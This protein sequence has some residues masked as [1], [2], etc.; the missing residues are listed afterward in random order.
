MPRVVSSPIRKYGLYDN[1]AY[2]FTCM[3]VTQKLK[4]WLQ[5]A[6]QQY[7]K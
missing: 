2:A 7:L 1:L 3:Y 5:N 6:A 4:C